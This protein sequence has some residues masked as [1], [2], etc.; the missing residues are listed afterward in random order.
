MSGAV[1]ILLISALSRATTSGGVARGAKKP[2][3]RLTSK[4][5]IPAASA[6]VGT[7]GRRRRASGGRNRD[8]LERIR[9]HL[10]DRG[11]E[12]RE[13]EVDV[14]A[15]KIVQRGACA[16]VGHMGDI[17]PGAQLEQFAGE[18]ARGAGAR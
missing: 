10:G 3:Q 11:G 9:L 17:G 14:P 2:C 12:A 8:Q 7:V 1:M 6:T 4:S 18:M 15:Q 16:L 13:E 5:A